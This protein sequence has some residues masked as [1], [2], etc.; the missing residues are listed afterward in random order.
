MNFEIVQIVQE[1]SNAG[2]VETVAI[3][4]AGVFGRNGLSNV[5]LA[6]TVAEKLEQSNPCRGARPWPGDDCTA[7]E[8]LAVRLQ[9]LCAG[10]AGCCSRLLGR[11]A[12]GFDRHRNGII[13]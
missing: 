5:V 2:G 3:E 10:E 13:G 1:I 9:R 8:G 7:G 6:S 4:L 12:S 11:T